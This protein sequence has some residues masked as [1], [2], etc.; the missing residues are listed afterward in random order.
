MQR[1]KR[2]YC[3]GKVM[4]SMKKHDGRRHVNIPV[5]IPHLG[6]PNDCVFC[7]QRKISGKLQYDRTTAEHEINVALQTIDTENTDVEIAYFG[8]S[9]T[10][11]DREEMIYLLDTAKKFTDSGKVQSIRLST[12]PDYISPEILDILK[13]YEVR[14][15]ELGIQSMDD[16]VLEACHRGHTSADTIRACGLIKDAGFGLVGQMM[17]GLP[18]ADLVSEIETAEKICNLGADG[19]RI[20][21]TVVLKETELAEMT[22]R[23]YECGKCENTKEYYAPLTLEESV[24]RAREALFVFHANNVP[25]IRIGLCSAENLTSGSDIAAGEYHCAIG[26]LVQSSLYMKLIDER[27]SEYGR[28]ALEGKTLVIQVP[29]GEISKVAGQKRCNKLKI[30]NE[31][32]VK[33]IKIIENSILAEYNIIIGIL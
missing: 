27:L 26:E 11:I 23:Y 14:Y 24:L 25:V 20:Y 30:Q 10:G 4:K 2:S 16:R 31:Y 22:K 19:A 28:E 13:R 18:G 21:P 7:N 6:C 15:I 3:L 29:C 9:F 12:R 5:F 8:G 33:N 1:R 17:T 32:N